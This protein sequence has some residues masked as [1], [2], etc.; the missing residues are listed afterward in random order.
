MQE[1]GK[2]L[3]RPADNS[4]PTIESEHN[5]WFAPAIITWVAGNATR[6][7]MPPGFP[8]EVAQCYNIVIILE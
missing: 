2:A 8:V 1:I 3:A 6:T 5:A 4:T 7:V